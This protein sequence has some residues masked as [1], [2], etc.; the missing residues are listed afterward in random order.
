[1]K[2]YA[3]VDTTP[4][5]VRD[6]TFLP[7]PGQTRY[8]LTLNDEQV[9]LLAQGICSEALAERAFALLWWKRQAQRVTSRRRVRP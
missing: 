8:H 7:A 9:E 6:E 1:M 4:D 2:P 5:E 3:V